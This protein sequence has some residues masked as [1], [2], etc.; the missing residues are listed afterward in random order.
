M[1]EENVQA[2]A[3]G[4]EEVEVAAGQ[5]GRGTMRWTTVMSSFVLR[6]MCQLISIGVRTDK[7]FKEVHLNKVAKDLIE[8]TGNE[9]TGTQSLA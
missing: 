8:F 5:R 9:V 7:S 4:V 6:R 3:D 1:A 2:V